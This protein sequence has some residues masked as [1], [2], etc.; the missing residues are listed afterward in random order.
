MK[1]QKEMTSFFSKG[2]RGGKIH[3]GSS[4]WEYIPQGNLIYLSYE[5]RRKHNKYDV[6]QKMRG[7]SKS[8]DEKETEESRQRDGSTYQLID[9]Q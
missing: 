6:F 2:G 8:Q 7:V 3:K 1:Y 9:L 5:E 4:K